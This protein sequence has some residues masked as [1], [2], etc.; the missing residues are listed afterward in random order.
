MHPENYNGAKLF[1]SSQV[2]Y[3]LIQKQGDL[4]LTFSIKGFKLLFPP[5]FE[6]NGHAAY[7]TSFRIL[8][9]SASWI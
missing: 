5:S 2:S 7:Q 3:I 1:N 6:S 9:E 4:N 8:N